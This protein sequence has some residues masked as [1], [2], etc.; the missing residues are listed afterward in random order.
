MNHLLSIT[1]F[2]PAIWA[3]NKTVHLL[4]GARYAY[5]GGLLHRKCLQKEVES[6]LHALLTFNKVMVIGN[7]KIQLTTL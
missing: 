6:A 5:F 1:S 4:L 3:P 7:K 2:Q